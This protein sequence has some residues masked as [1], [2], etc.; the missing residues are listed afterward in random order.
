[1]S[2]QSDL[3]LRQLEQRRRMHTVRCD[4]LRLGHRRRMVPAEPHMQFWPL[5]R[6]GLWAK[7]PDNTDLYVSHNVNIHAVAVAVA[8]Q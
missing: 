8:E 5:R 6:H 4:M 3:L 2:R 1:M 7:S